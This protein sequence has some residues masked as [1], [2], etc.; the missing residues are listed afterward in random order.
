MPRRWLFALAFVAGC[1]HPGLDGDVYRAKDIAF[2][3]GERPPSWRSLEVSHATLAWR[4]EAREGS[5]LLNARCGGG[6]DATP[7]RALAEQLV[8]GTTGREWTATDTVP[9]DGREA[10]HGRLSAK[11]DGVP[12]GYDVFVLRK[13]GCIYDFVYVAPPDR[14][15]E[16]VPGFERFVQGFHTVRPG[17]PS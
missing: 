7:L 6:G 13:D 11:L 9:F 16:G 8:I 10:I 2:R 12:M 17:N 4:D 14:L 3:V 5:I 15:E 1:A